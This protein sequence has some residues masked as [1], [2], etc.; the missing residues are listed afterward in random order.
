MRNRRRSRV[1]AGVVVTALIAGLAGAPSA[2]AG[3]MSGQPTAQPPEQ[4]AG[5]SKLPMGRVTLLTGDRVAVGAGGQVQ[6]TPGAGRR[7]QFEQRVGKDQLFVIPSDVARDV[8]TG[9][10]DRSLFDVA[11]LIKQGLDDRS[12]AEIPL[13]VT[14]AA[15]PK[16]LAGAK[17]AGQLPAVDGTAVKVGKRSATTFLKQLT[18]ARAVAGVKKVWLDAKLRPTLDQSVPQIGAP[19]AW[20]AGYTGSGV[21]VAVVD[22]GVDA[23]H[24]DLKPVLAGARNFSTDPAGDQIG[25][26]THVASIIA[27]SAAASNGKYKGVAPGAKLYDAKVCELDGCSMSAMIA[28]MEWAATD[29]KAKV[30]NV[31]IGGPDDPEIDPV[32]EAVNR[33]TAQTGALFVVAAG[34]SGEDGTR[35][36]ESPGSAD[37]AL[38]V[39]AVDKQDRLATFSSRGPRLDGAVKPDVTAPGAGIVAARAKDGGIGTPV[40]D[41]Y[42]SLNGTSMATPHVAGAAAILAQQHPDWTAPKLKAQL[43]ATAKQLDGQSTFE[44]GNGRVDVAKAVS[45]SFVPT[46]NSLSFGTASYPHDDDQPVTKTLGYRNDGSAPVELSLAATLVDQ[47]GKPAPEGAVRL[48]ATTLTVPVGGTAEVPVTLATNNA[49]PNGYYSG[50]VTASAGG[51]SVSTT[52]AIYK[53]IE[54]H[55]LTVKHLGLDGKPAPDAYSSVFTKEQ[56]PIDLQDP[57]GTVKIRL[58]KDDYMLSG[59]L[60]V[61]RPGKDEPAKYRM[62]RPMLHLTEDT[63]VVMDARLA[64]PIQIS[65]PRR[66]AVLTVGAAGLT[67]P[68]DWYFGLRYGFD[69]PTAIFTA[70]IGPPAPGVTGD[71]STRWARRNADGTFDNSPYG[72]VQV[73]K[74]PGRYPTGIRRTLDPAKM[75]RVDQTFNAT[76]GRRGLVSSGWGFGY[77]DEIAYDLPAKRTLFHDPAPDNTPRSEVNTGASEFDAGAPDVSL[78]EMNRTVAP[79]QAGRHYREAFNVAAFAPAPSY[80]FREA[81]VLGLVISPLADA[82]GGGGGGITTAADSRTSKLYR[83]GVLISDYDNRFG[84]AN[85]IGLPPEPATYKLVST[86]DRHSVSRFSTKVEHSWTFRSGA[87]TEQVLLPALG[88]RYRPVVDDHNLTPRKKT[89]PVPVVIDHQTGA[90]LPRIDKFTVEYADGAAADW[91]PVKLV[92]T[93]AGQYVAQ[94][95]APAGASVS[96]R[97]KVVDG[98]GN[99]T[100]QTVTDAIRFS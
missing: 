89:L 70:Q 22:S 74:L 41:N 77:A 54:H 64:R 57:S 11:G 92:R 85:P 31:S 20:Q 82:G 76:S 17:A 52:L 59:T 68:G 6:V 72:F 33:L 46:V 66:D 4:P 40:D 50:R 67:M 81:D 34:N 2:R 78:T 21:R 36:I 8:A 49:G 61:A 69:D 12:T 47:D 39:G 88:I 7:V 9:K 32:E 60:E 48:G 97:A 38:T 42:T 80:A 84:W 24:P 95:P 15:K 23:N 63:T 29:V 99:Q 14:Y 93:A 87:S 5:Q 37:A 25:H 71:L 44:Q 30:I 79:Y 18:G 75:V 28:G 51:Q 86:L 83:D 90:S 19:A 26:G 56:W 13:I 65:V 43:A 94:F 27:G 58:P 45:V 1:R 62:V 10:L 55:T 100:E 35:T 3:E 98:D 91:K 96:L 53:E 73:E 16:T